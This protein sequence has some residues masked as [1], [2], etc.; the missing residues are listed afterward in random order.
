MATRANAVHTAP[1]VNHI[2]G[3]NDGVSVGPRYTPYLSGVASITIDY[4]QKSSQKGFIECSVG[5][6]IYLLTSEGWHRFQGM[7][8]GY[9][10]DSIK[11]VLYKRPALKG[12]WKGVCLRASFIILPPEDQPRVVLNKKSAGHQ[13][14]SEP[15][16]PN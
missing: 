5:Y 12:A 1:R 7:H 4:R 10:M 16:R 6:S 11:G 14:G 15:T 2:P 9:I 3:F 8:Q 13:K